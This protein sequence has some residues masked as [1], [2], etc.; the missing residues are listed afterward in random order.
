VVVSRGH[1]HSVDQ[2][3]GGDWPFSDGSVGG[4]DVIPTA[5]FSPG[6]GRGRELLLEAGTDSTESD[7]D[8]FGIT[9]QR[10][11]HTNPIR[12]FRRAGLGPADD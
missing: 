2:Q 3:V 8:Q 6:E 5:G 7:R 4:R 11:L 10:A 9:P 12:V 1:G